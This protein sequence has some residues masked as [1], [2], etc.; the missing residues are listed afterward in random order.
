MTLGCL[1]QIGQTGEAE[2]QDDIQT[3][4]QTPNLIQQAL[5]LH[6]LI[7]IKVMTHAGA[8]ILLITEAFSPI[9][10]EDGGHGRTVVENRIK[11]V[12][13]FMTSTMTMLQMMVMRTTMIK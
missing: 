1:G 3:P 2:V 12:R 10:L 4:N 11:H 9:H 7:V 6:H 8:A 13:K 5:I